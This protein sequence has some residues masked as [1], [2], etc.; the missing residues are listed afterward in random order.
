MNPMTS[1][2]SRTPG[3]RTDNTYR[4]AWRG[5]AQYRARS[6]LITIAIALGVSMI[7][8]SDVSGSGFRAGFEN[9]VQVEEIRQSFSFMFD[10][11]EDGLLAVGVV[12]LASSSFLIF[13]AFTMSLTQRESQIATLRCLGMTTYKVARLLIVEGLIVGIVGIVAGIVVGLLLANGI[14]ALMGAAGF[15][16]AGGIISTAGLLK[17]VGFGLGSVMLALFFPARRAMR[18]APIAA[19]RNPQPA[20]SYSGRMNALSWTG[21]ALITCLLLYLLVAP[22]GNW[23]LPPWNTRMPLIL[24]LVWLIALSM[25]VPLVIG[26]M[27]LA[28]AKALRRSTSSL[29]RLAVDN[30]R[31][32]GRRVTWT[33]LAFVIGIAMIVSLTGIIRFSVDVLFRQVAASS[34]LRPRW[35]ITNSQPSSE[36][37]IE[38]LS[39]SP[40]VIAEARRL[41]EGRADVGG[42]YYV[43][44][45]EISAMFSN[46]P[47][48][49]A[50]L[51]FVV[52]SG[53]FV[54][55]DGDKETARVLFEAGCSVLLTP[56]VA[57]RLSVEAGDTL[58][59]AGKD[60]EVLCTVAGI[61]SGGYIYPT[62]FVSTTAR[63]MF[64]IGSSPSMIYVVLQPG[65]ERGLFDQDLAGLQERF[66]LAAN[67]APVEDTF[68]IVFE[69][70]ETFTTFLSRLLILALAAAGLGLVNTTM[71]SVIE[72][73]RELGILQALGATRSQVT[74]VVISEGVLIGVIGGVIGLIAGVGLSMIFALSYGGQTYGLPD[75]PL[76]KA[77]W[78]ATS[79]A[80]RHG[81]LALLAIPFLSALSAWFPCRSIVHSSPIE[82]MF[83]RADRTGRLRS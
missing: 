13:N 8:A 80:L 81:V 70:R 73:R 11:F 4:L 5:L 37:S 66:G 47:S 43:L 26:S 60:R 83:A 52:E 29:G 65:A 75:L 41:A 38:A 64:N 54:F 24:S 2:S 27:S 58:F 18:I 9:E 72:R 45:P 68:S 71:M 7:V 22:P 17:A 15:K 44:A 40:D 56:G 3:I 48:I 21:L 20:I 53:G 25:M 42:F 59:L 33:V 10:A 6:V 19:L 35:L 50:D 36:P 67:V 30:L 23:A 77:G 82:T 61:G 78:E 16:T 31:R 74:M 69:L 62:S 76:W 51:D 1:R 46:F 34:V 32:D 49:M 39:I 12:I 55:T 14:L 63:D 28:L 79:P 57:A